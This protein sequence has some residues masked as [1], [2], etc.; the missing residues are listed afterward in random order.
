[1]GQENRIVP[2]IWCGVFVYMNN[3][4]KEKIDDLCKHNKKIGDC[5]Y[6]YCENFTLKIPYNSNI[7]KI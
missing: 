4:K 6:I 7:A 5:E 1:M 2:V 3:T